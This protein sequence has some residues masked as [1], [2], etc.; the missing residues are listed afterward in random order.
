MPFKI[1]WEHA[2]VYR[3]YYGDV[4]VAER[5]ASLDVICGDRRFDDLRYALTN[6]LEVQAYESSAEATAEIAAMHIGPMFT[7]PQILIVAVAQREDILSAITDFQRLGLV[8]TPY[9][10]F[11]TVPE[12]RAWI[13]SQLH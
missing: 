13:H 3:H 12:A 4:T 9:V 8:R 10:V 1:D 2:G 5:R 6:Y 11:P 7:N